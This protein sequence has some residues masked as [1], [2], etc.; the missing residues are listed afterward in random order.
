MAPE[1][2][3]HG[4]GGAPT[5]LRRGSKWLLSAPEELQMAPK[6]SGG[7]PTW[8]LSAPEELQMAPKSSG[9]APTWLLSAPKGL[10]S[11]PT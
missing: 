7:A 5:W 4:S 9:G 1:G 2:L 11:A 10:L 6:S 3:R 8:L